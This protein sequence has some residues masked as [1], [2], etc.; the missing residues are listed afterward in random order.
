E[1]RLFAVDIEHGKARRL[2]S[3]GAVAE[4][5]LN[6]DTLV[7]SRHTLTSPA[8]LFRADP[9]GSNATQISNFN[10]ARL[11]E[12]AMGEFEQF[13]FAGWNDETV[14]GYVVKPWNYQKGRKVPVAFIIHGGPQGS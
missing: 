13:S 8:Q 9:D 1:H 11:D 10:R 12:I 4:F 6:A 7:F 5:D 14:H 2:V 3:G